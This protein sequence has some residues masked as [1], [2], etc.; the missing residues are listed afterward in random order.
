M[1]IKVR[2]KHII[3]M[4]G[5]KVITTTYNKLDDAGNIVVKNAKDTFYAVDQE[6]LAAIAV[7]DR[8]V[9]EKRF[10]QEG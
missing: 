10:G 7:I 3:E 6:L 5:A 8:Y 9:N 2:S 4:D 1:S